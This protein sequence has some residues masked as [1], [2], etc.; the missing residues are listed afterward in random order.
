MFDLYIQTSQELK[1]RLMNNIESKG[2]LSVSINPA[3]LMK[4]LF[5]LNITILKH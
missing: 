3:D 4:G 1:W 2:N 5:C